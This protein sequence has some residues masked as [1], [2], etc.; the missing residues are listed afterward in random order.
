MRRSRRGKRLSK[1]QI[2]QIIAEAAKFGRHIAEIE[3]DA[4][5]TT[6]LRF[7]ADGGS[8]LF[9]EWAERL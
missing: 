2:G 7:A 4:T 3:V 5:G 1:T 8:D 9:H 6:R